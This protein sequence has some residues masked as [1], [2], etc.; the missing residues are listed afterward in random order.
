MN[1]LDRDKTEIT[2]LQ[3]LLNFVEFYMKTNGPTNMSCVSWDDWYWKSKIPYVE[4]AIARINCTSFEEARKVQLA[5]FKICCMVSNPYYVANGSKPLKYFEIKN[6]EGKTNF[7]ATLD[8]GSEE[9]KLN[10]SG[11]LTY[12]YE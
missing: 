12:Y 6:K 4:Q 7:Y 10:H 5:K 1:I 11:T 9:G 2:D 8:Y 3:S